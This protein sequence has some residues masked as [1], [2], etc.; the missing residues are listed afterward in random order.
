MRKDAPLTIDLPAPGRD[1]PSWVKVGIIAAVGFV[2]GVAWPRV[3]GVRLGPSAPGEAAAAA[4]AAASASGAPGKTAPAPAVVVAS[5]PS[6]SVAVAP[7]PSAA[8]GGQP[9]VSVQKGSVLGCKGE[10]GENKKGKDCGAVGSLDQMVAPRLKK[11]ST[12]GAAEGQNGKLSFVIQADFAQNRMSWDIGKSSTVTNTEG[13]TTCLKTIFQGVV[14][15]GMAHENPRYTVAY[16]VTF[17]PGAEDK[18]ADK[19]ADDT[20]AKPADTTTKPSETTKTTENTSAGG[21]AIVSWEVALIRDTPKTGTVIAR[22]PRGSKVKLG[23]SKDGW[24]AI[25][26]G[27]GFA[28]NGYVYHSALGK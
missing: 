12:C 10:D 8:G 2:I 1:H 27:D 17:A 14:L 15:T 26:Y 24:Y 9:N 13:L 21:E 11:L 23:S 18:T 22:L 5:K 16:A 6:A 4:A 19:K 20:S 3:M 25:Q 28:S 7:V